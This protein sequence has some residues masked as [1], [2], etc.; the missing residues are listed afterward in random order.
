MDGNLASRAVL[1]FADYTAQTLAALRD[2]ASRLRLIDLA[3]RLE[4]ACVEAERARN[5]ADKGLH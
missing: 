4:A 5:A 2:T 3:R 1:E